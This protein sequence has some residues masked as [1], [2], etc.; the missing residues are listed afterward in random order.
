MTWTNLA[1]S[2]IPMTLNGILAVLI[3]A[4]LSANAPSADILSQV[5]QTGAANLLALMEEKDT[6]MRTALVIMDMYILSPIPIRKHLMC[7]V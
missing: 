5:L 6:Q 4:L 7:T 3:L 1:L 2:A